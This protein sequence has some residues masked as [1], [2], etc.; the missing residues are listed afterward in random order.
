MPR[1]QSEARKLAPE[2][3]EAEAPLTAPPSKEE[4]SFSPEYVKSARTR[5]TEL[6]RD[7]K[8]AENWGTGSETVAKLKQ[9]IRELEQFIRKY[10]KTE[11][12]VIPGGAPEVRH[13]ATRAPLEVKPRPLTVKEID[14]TIA[15]L[16]EQSKNL[17]G[18]FSKALDTKGQS[19]IVKE[20]IE[21]VNKELAELRARREEIIN[22]TRREAGS[23]GKPT[24]EII[25]E[26]GRSFSESRRKATVDA[27][28]EERR[29]A[30]ADQERH[31]TIRKLEVRQSGLAETEAEA[32]FFAADDE[33]AA[34]RSEGMRLLGSELSPEEAAREWTRMVREAPKSGM[35]ARQN[36]IAFIDSL[37]K[38]FPEYVPFTGR[39]YFDITENPKKTGFWKR[40]FGLKSEAAIRQKKM[41]EAL[42]SVPNI[43]KLY[44]TFLLTRGRTHGKGTAPMGVKGI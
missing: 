10:G 12:R 28:R 39:D 21:L 3:P 7:F 4:P 22:R 18:Q 33:E 15:E 19:A 37:H 16:S 6:R 25:Q 27:E 11:L 30:A 36:V 35:E 8:E 40:V 38:T 5:L 1:N 31:R 29:I 24:K 34:L 9:E 20:Q 26:M 32:K 41:E 42:E 2:I 13:K 17:G 23:R 43:G 14:A 44:T